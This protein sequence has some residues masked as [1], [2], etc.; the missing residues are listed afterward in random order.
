MSRHPILNLHQRLY[1]QCKSISPHVA[2][3]IVITGNIVLFVCAFELTQL[4]IKL[5]D[6]RNRKLL[7][8]ATLD[9]IE[10]MML[11]IVTTLSL[12]LIGT[13]VNKLVPKVNC[14]AQITNIAKAFGNKEEKEVSD[15]L[16]KSNIC[17]SARRYFKSLDITQGNPNNVQKTRLENIIAQTDGRALLALN[18]VAWLPSVVLGVCNATGIRSVEKVL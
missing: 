17:E 2:P 10:L 14:D 13:A 9:G 1:D 4:C 16:E 3:T 7:N 6:T 12:C 15:I 5:S 8:F 11:A 18:P